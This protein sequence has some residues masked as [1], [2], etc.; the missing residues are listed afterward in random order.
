V[1]PKMPFF[2]GAAGG[3][4]P[5]AP[6][7]RSRLPRRSLL[8]AS[9]LLAFAASGAGCRGRPRHAETADGAVAGASFDGP[10]VVELDLTHGEPEIVSSPLLGSAPHRAHADLVLTLR[11]LSEHE[12]PKGIFVRLGGAS[13]ELACAEEIGV[14][15][16]ELRKRGVP[17]VCHADEYGNG[18]YLLAATGCSKLWLSPAGE[19]SAVGLAAQLLYAHHLLDKLQ[20]GVD[21]L[22]IGKFKGAEEPFTRDGPSPEARAS[23]E[24]ALHGMRA[25]WLTAIGE[26]RARPSIADL[27]E[28]G[29]FAPE[30]AKQ[31]GLVDEVGYADDARDDAEKAAGTGRTVIRFGTSEGGKGTPRGIGDLLRALSGS[32]RIGTPHITVVRAVGAI[33]MTSSSPLPIGGGGEGI[34][35][36]DLG[37]TLGRLSADGSV[38]AVVLRIDSPG[39]SALASD[40][41][42]KKLMK[43]RADKPL[44]VS[45]GG[46]AASG[47]YY[48]ASA[49]TKILAEPTSLLGS[50]G[51]VGGKLTFDKTLEEIGVH[52]ET[53]PAATDPKKAARAGYL[54]SLTDWDDATRQKVLVSMQAVY[55]LFLR[56]VAEG[57]GVGVEAIA[58]SAEGRVFGGV[59]AKERGMID[60]LGGLAE[61]LAMARELGR[62]PENAPIDVLGEG[63]GLL[64]LLDPGGSEEAQ[65]RA[66]VEEV[67]EGAQRKALSAMAAPWGEALP[68]AGR[69]VG[70]LAPFL[71]GERVLAAVPFAIVV[72]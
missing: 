67:A 9:V 31:Q 5:R 69:F 45:V 7:E 57:R 50:I 35:E 13:V 6:A 26:G 59:E 55:D 27:V 48:L 47:G 19:V 64:D 68:E 62:L 15:L 16:G 39:G 14:L 42:W 10:A 28:D 40:L 3:P 22:Q 63:G 41:L 56:R 21:F 11:S 60:E 70:S 8:A 30:D 4:Q 1:T 61:A 20:I 49:G 38:K 66:G 43:I 37:Q 44:V 52:A 23:L 24:G 17:V 32:S 18:T 72:R 34:S 53:M 65:G 12:L 2:D 29:P 46:M 25:A 58:P 51:V 33:S 71:Q 36:R 54:S